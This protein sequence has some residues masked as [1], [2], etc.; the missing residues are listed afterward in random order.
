MLPHQA[1]EWGSVKGRFVYQ[2][3]FS[4]PEKIKV[5]KD[6]NFCSQKELVDETLVVGKKGGLANVFVYLYVKRN[7]TIP[8]HPNLKEV[9]KKPAVLECKGCRYEPHALL[10]RT[11]Q[12]LEIRYVDQQIGHSVNLATFSNPEYGRQVSMSPKE[13]MAFEKTEPIPTPISCSVHAWMNAHVLIRD[14]P[15]MALSAKRWPFRDQE[16]SHRQARIDLLA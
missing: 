9:S 14:N 10:L 12:K 6:V 3:K 7:S 2:G 1:A 16:S 15:Y 4:K 11:T 5:T 13:I 8:I